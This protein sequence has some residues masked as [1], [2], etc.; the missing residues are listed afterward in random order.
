MGDPTITMNLTTSDSTLS[1]FLTVI[2]Y[3]SIF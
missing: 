1:G 2:L 3:F